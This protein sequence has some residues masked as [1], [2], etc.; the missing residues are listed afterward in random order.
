MARRLRRGSAGQR[1]H[2]DDDGR[3]GP[4]AA[5]GRRVQPFLRRRSAAQVDV[6][7][8]RRLAAR[9]DRAGAVLLRGRAPAECGG[10]AERV[11]GRQAIGALPA[12][13]HPALLQSAA[14]QIVGGG[15]RPE[16][17][18]AADGAKPDAVRRPRRLLRL[19]HVRRDLS[20]RRAV[21]AR[22]HVQA[23]RRAEEDRPARSH[24]RPAARRRR[25]TFDDRGGAGLSPGSACR[26]R[27]VPREDV[28]D[29]VRVLL[30]AAPAAAVRELAVSEWPREQLGNR[31]PVHE[32]SFV[33]FGDGEH[34][35][36]DLPRAEHDP[37]SHLA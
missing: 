24:A 2:L 18:R 27:R 7:S 30:D 22:L 34:Q 35:H 6:R 15:E 8:R 17:R 16:V 31:R 5:L 13:A 37:Q 11:R 3:R 32:R 28:R 20:V 25:H 26:L 1:A 14:S 36:A 29:R 12:A 33:R 23:A 19:R 4:R 10:R 9:V 21:F